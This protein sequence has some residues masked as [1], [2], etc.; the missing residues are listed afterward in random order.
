MI[1]GGDALVSSGVMESLLQVLEWRAIQPMNI[2]VSLVNN[3]VSW[4]SW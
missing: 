1:I 2:T 3:I 4:L